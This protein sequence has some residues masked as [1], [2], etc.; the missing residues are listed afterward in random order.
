MEKTFF[1][2]RLRETVECGN[3][4]FGIQLRSCS[5]RIAEMIGYFGFDFI[6]LESEHFVCNDE[7]MED[8]F[9]ASE[10]SGCTPIVRLCDNLPGHI[11][12]II[13]AG[14]KGI[15]I[16]HV[17]T[18]EEAAEIVRAVKFPPLGTRSG[19]KSRFSGYGIVPAKEVREMANRSVLAIAMIESKRGIDNLEAILETGIDMIRIGFNDLAQDLGHPGDVHHEEVLLAAVKI[20]ETARTHMVPVGAKADSVEEAR[21][22]AKIGITHFS[23]GSDLS[24]LAKAFSNMKR[25]YGSL[26]KELKE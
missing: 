18:A 20:V 9:R 22:L 16:P 24:I 11:S 1:Y 26:S 12:Q 8:I 13:E 23:L 5:K 25:E 14:A 15:I 3:I 19:T 2:N 4:A 6:Y 17:E 7:T 10:L 21:M